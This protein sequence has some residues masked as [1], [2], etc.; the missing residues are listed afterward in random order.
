ME[1]FSEVY[2]EVQ[3]GS[4]SCADT[5][6]ILGCSARHFLRPRERFDD[7][8]HAA[9]ADRRVGRVSPQRAA[10]EEVE[11]FTRLYRDKYM[12]FNSVTPH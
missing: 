12:G 8:G 5:A 2:D 6:L 1:R 11:K 10:D 4:L 7:E 9:L 3:L